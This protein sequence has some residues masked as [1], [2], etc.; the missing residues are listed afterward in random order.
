M[1]EHSPDSL[2]TDYDSLFHNA[3]SDVGRG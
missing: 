2:I 3:D 1:D